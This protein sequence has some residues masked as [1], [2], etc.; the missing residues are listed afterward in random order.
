MYRR[1]RTIRKRKVGSHT[2][3]RKMYG[4]YVY[5]R[6]KRDSSSSLQRS[7]AILFDTHRHTNVGE[8]KCVIL[9]TKRMRVCE[10]ERTCVENVAKR[11]SEHEFFF[12][13]LCVWPIVSLSVMT[14]YTCFRVCKHKPTLI[15]RGTRSSEIFNATKSVPD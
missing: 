6:A 3:S 2:L 13:S 15:G 1:S 4:S 14:Q 8:H 10:D 11:T 9:C 5:T 12:L 7:L